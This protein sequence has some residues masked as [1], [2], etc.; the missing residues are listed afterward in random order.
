[1]RTTVRNISLC[2][3]IVLLIGILAAC[4]ISKDELVGSWTG[5]YTYNGNRFDVAIVFKSSGSYSKATMKNGTLSSTETGDW[6][7][8]GGKVILYSDAATYHGVSTTYNY[9]GGKL[10]N[11]NHYFSKID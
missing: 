10:E 5:T 2:L 4:G 7:I 6:E 1:M 11:N 3:V 9:K 8:K